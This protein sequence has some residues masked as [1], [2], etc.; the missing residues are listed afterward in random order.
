[1]QLSGCVK[2]V[3]DD[4]PLII[5][6]IMSRVIATTVHVGYAI[7]FVEEASFIVVE[8]LHV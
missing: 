3:V 2:I 6:I 7:K 8:T 5:C 1:V 4:D